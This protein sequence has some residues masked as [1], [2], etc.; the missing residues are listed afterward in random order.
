MITSKTLRGQQFEEY[1]GD[2]YLKIDVYLRYQYSVGDQSYSSTRLNAIKSASYP[3][4]EVENYSEG[5]VVG[6]YYDPRD[7]SRSV[8]EPGFEWSSKAFDG[9]SLISTAAGL[10]LLGRGI[11]IKSAGR[12]R[13]L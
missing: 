12:R 5:D 13:K 10:L 7:P 6:V 1:D 8:L 9:F 3:K 11:K 4:E 2:L